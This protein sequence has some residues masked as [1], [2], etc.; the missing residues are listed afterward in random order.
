MNLLLELLIAEI[1]QIP[2]LVADFRAL[3]TAHPALSPTDMAAAIVQIST[4]T[5]AAADAILAKA[6]ADAPKP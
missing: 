1:P 5:D 4:S 2:K 3:L 6:A